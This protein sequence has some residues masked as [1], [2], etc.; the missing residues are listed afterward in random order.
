MCRNLC[1]T[2]KAATC[3]RDGFRVRGLK[4]TAVAK[5]SRH[6]CVHLA[7][8]GLCTKGIL[9]TFWLPDR[10]TLHSESCR[11][12]ATGHDHRPLRVPQSPGGSMKAVRTILAAMVFLTLAAALSSAQTQ[13]Y[14]AQNAA[15]SNNGSS[16]ANA[17]AVSTLSSGT[18]CW[19]YDS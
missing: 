12:P 10:I 17:R 11:K 14:V 19:Q 15:G 18:D 5:F 6:E 7:T 3:R 4:R 8:L 13:I 9:H 2:G 16:R 1:E